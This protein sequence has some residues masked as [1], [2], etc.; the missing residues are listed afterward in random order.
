MPPINTRHN[1]I[2]ENTSANLPPPI[3]R[4]EAITAPKDASS[5]SHQSNIW[6]L[7]KAL[8]RGPV[9]QAA[10]AAGLYGLQ[11]FHEFSQINEEAGIEEMALYDAGFLLLIL[12]LPAFLML[13]RKGFVSAGVLCAVAAFNS[14]ACYTAWQAGAPMYDI[15]SVISN[16]FFLGMFGR[17][18][19]YLWQ[20]RSVTS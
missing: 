16:L 8:C 6:D 15:G 20:N 11:G 1:T 12:G 7:C 3:S 5:F 13:K 9:R 10:I 2:A 19:W 18:A 17:A 4:Q 14:W